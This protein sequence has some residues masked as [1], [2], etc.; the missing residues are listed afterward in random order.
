MLSLS[1]K[2]ATA[3]PAKFQTDMEIL[4]ADPMVS[5]LWKVLRLEVS[6]IESDT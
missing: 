1:L 4:A 5:S 2:F 3:A 6:Y